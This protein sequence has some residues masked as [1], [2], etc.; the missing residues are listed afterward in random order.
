MTAATSRPD[1]PLLERILDTSTLESRLAQ[2]VGTGVATVWL[3]PRR[4]ST[5]LRRATH[6]ASG[7]LGVVGG[8]LAF[9]EAPRRM[10][11]AA[12]GGFGGALFAASI[13]GFAL[14]EATESWLRERGVKRP[15]LL[16]GAA[17]GVFTYVTSR[18]AA[19]ALALAEQRAADPGT[20]EPDEPL[21]ERPDDRA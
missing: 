7:F 8:G 20:A 1:A 19:D 16:I 18:P 4:M 21:D 2:S 3:S 11:V 12:A 13:L 14:D 10:Q 9:A 6:V 17:A 5:P 15:R